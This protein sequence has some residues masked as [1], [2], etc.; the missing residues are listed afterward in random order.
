MVSREAYRII[1]EGLSNA[2][3]HAGPVPLTLRITA[4]EG[5]LTI[6]ME[7]PVDPVAGP[8]ATRAGGGRG[9][10]GIAERATLLGGGAEWGAHDGTWR[11]VARLP[12]GG[13][14]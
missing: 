2:L 14:R 5:A 10:R 1:Q 6:A 9:L 8:H 7:N 12:L 11:L 3:R 13:T 4:A